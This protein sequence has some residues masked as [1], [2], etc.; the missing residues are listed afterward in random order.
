LVDDASEDPDRDGLTNLEEYNLGRHPQNAEPAKPE[1]SSPPKDETGASLTPELQTE[2][3]SDRDVGDT[4]AE[5]EWQIS[6]VEGDFTESSLVLRATCDSHLTSLTVPEYILRV[7]SSYYWR[8]KFHDDRGA[9]SRWS[10]VSSFTTIDALASDDPDQDGVPEAQEITD[11][12]V[13]L[14]DDGTPDMDQS[15]TANMKCA[16]T[17]IGDGQVAVK[18]GTN[19]A[20][21]DSL[22]SIDPATIAY[23]RG[24]P[25]EMPL[26]IICFKLTVDNPGDIAEVTVYLSEPAPSNVKWYKY[27]PVN[28]WQDYSAHATFSGDRKSVV[29]ELKDG[30]YGD[31]DGVANGIIVDP[32]GPGT[33]SV[34]PAPPPP[35]GGGGGGCFIGV[36]TF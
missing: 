18:Q 14:D 20:S 17:V 23:T 35:S 10:L 16:N 4:H 36:A 2:A 33:A 26:G 32:S 22:M 25:D 1:L 13:D 9:A 5:T 6:T 3:F 8:A 29:L 12:T 24:R 31:A 27:D 34:T 19:V 7:N 28:G 15:M 21:I 30:D 11:D